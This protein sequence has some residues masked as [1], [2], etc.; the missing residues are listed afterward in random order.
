MASGRLAS[1]ARV[2]A[3]TDAV[4]AIIVTLL[5]VELAPPSN[6]AVARL[7][8]WRAL[9]MQWP[10]FLA[11]AISFLLVEQIWM[12]HHAMWR[13]VDRV[14]RPILV[15]QLLHLFFVFLIPLTSRLLAEHLAAPHT[16]GPDT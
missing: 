9:L 8:L 3:F 6:E 14:D 5:A 16:P 1:T 15:L 2:D 13:W 10:D 11:F 12:S 7:G 4:L